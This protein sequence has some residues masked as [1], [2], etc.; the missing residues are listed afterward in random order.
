[1]SHKTTNTMK[2]EGREIDAI[3]M[4]FIFTPPVVILKLNLILGIVSLIFC[5]TAFYKAKMFIHL[6]KEIPH[7]DGVMVVFSTLLNVIA[8]ALS[9]YP[10]NDY[11]SLMGVIIIFFGMIISYILIFSKMK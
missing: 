2:T 9:F 5:Y 10:E 7:F 4:A 3:I 8:V 1:M 11:L 6:R